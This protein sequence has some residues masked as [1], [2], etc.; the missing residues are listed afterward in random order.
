METKSEYKVETEKSKLI[1]IETPGGEVIVTRFAAIAAAMAEAALSGRGGRIMRITGEPGTG[2]TRISWLLEKSMNGVRICASDGMS[3][4]AFLKQLAEKLGM[5]ARDSTSADALLESIAKAL[6]IRPA[7]ERLIL[8]D[9]AHLIRSQLL[10]TLRYLSDEYGA[11]V[12][13]FGNHLLIQRVFDDPRTGVHL[14]EF[15]RRIGTRNLHLT[16]ITDPAEFAKYF[17]ETLFGAVSKSVAA[18]FMKRANG[19]MAEGEELAGACKQYMEMNGLR[20]L[21]L[22]TVDAVWAEM[23]KR[24]V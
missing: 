24:T 4:R 21:T 11:A 5:P 18:R 1:R 15:A 2:K 13:L 7:A 6:T 8:V 20:E 3:R 16:P 22:E 19:F 14:T 10:N 23:A 9:E 12:A 17:L